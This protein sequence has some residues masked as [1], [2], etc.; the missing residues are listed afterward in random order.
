[1]ITSFL[2]T[3]IPQCNLKRKC[4][5]IL[6]CK[7]PFKKNLKQNQP[8]FLKERLLWMKCLFHSPFHR[9]EGK[10]KDQKEDLDKKPTK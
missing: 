6:P 8:T 7:A 9:I 4:F 5:S 10:N 1:M 2:Y 3:S